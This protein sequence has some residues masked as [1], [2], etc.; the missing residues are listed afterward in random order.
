MIDLDEVTAS[1]IQNLTVGFQPR[2][3]K[4]HAPSQLG[5][6]D[7]PSRPSLHESSQKG[8]RVNITAGFDDYNK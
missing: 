4:G 7:K 3:K 2:V 8:S 5:G 6:G 1:C